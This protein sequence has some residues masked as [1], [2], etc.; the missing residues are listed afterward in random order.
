[1]KEKEIP[2]ETLK[3]EQ[4]EQ[5]DNSK[6]LLWLA[7][8]V[9]IAATSVGNIFQGVSQAIRHDVNIVIDEDFGPEIEAI[10]GDIEREIDAAME[11]V[12]AELNAAELELQAA[13]QELEEA[14]Q[15]I[16]EALR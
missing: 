2:A 9:L 3:A 12:E 13:E 6:R 8:I 7:L 5:R 15:A 16:E 1:M 14:E 10:I 11:E 4:Q